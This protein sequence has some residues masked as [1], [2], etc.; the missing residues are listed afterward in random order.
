MPKL[1]YQY[2]GNERRNVSECQALPDG[3]YPK[4]FGE[5]E[6]TEHEHEERRRAMRAAG[7][8]LDYRSAAALDVVEGMFAAEYEDMLISKAPSDAV[9]LDCLVILHLRTRAASSSLSL[10]TRSTT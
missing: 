6:P 7:A 9:G 8:A 2:H 3:S 10:A 4:E 5:Y 1:S